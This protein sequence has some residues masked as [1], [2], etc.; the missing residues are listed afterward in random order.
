[1]G[2]RNTPVVEAFLSFSLSVLH[3]YAAS[4]ATPAEVNGS[5]WISHRI[6]VT[7]D[8]PTSDCYDYRFA[9]AMIGGG[10]MAQG[11]RAVVWQSEGCWFDPTLGVSK[12]P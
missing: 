3:G 12:Y 5:P 7:F 1:M 2:R 4:L 10:D 8:W 9:I 6:N 11:V